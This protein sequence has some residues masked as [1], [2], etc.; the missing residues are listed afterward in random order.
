MQLRDKER[1]RMVIQSIINIIIQSTI[2][3]R[4]DRDIK[5]RLFITTASVIIDS[6]QDGQR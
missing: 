3:T 2:T 4:G 5:E 6:I 1:E